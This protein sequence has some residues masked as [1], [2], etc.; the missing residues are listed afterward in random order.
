MQWMS[1]TAITQLLRDK[2]D[3]LGCDKFTECPDHAQHVHIHTTLQLKEIEIV[4]VTAMQ[5]STMH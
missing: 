2:P 1:M 4:Q 3:E 5:H